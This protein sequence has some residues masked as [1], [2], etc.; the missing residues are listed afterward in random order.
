MH[1][2]EL[3]N[4]ANWSAIIFF[5][6]H[7]PLKVRQQGA[8]RGRKYYDEM[9]SIRAPAACR[10]SPGRGTVEL[11]ASIGTPCTLAPTPTLGGGGG[12]AGLRRCWRGNQIKIIDGSI[13][14]SIIKDSLP[15]VRV[16]AAPGTAPRPAAEALRVLFKYLTRCREAPAARGA[17]PLL[18]GT[19][20]TRA[21]EGLA[22]ATLVDLFL[23]PQNNYQG[24]RGQGSFPSSP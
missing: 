1:R 8:R 23:L 5:P 3:I 2:K 15:G 21:S 17:S 24:R 12:A 16:T 19:T 11:W 14:H 7:V 10:A 20:R 22:L 9:L 6:F 13:F 4:A 18:W